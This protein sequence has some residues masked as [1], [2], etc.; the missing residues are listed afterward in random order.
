MREILLGLDGGGTHTRAV[1]VDR[2]GHVLASAEAGG[3]NPEHTPDAER[4]AHEAICRVVASAGRE[5]ADVTRIV[6]G[7]AGLNDPCDHVWAERQTDVPGLSCP[8]LQVNDAVIA[9]VGALR[10]QPGIIAISGTGS[11]VFGVTEAGRHVRNYDFGHYAPSSAGHLAR[12]A[13]YRLLIGDAKPADDGFAAQIFAHW[14]ADD[15][16]ALRQFAS[17]GFLVDDTA[18]NYRFG[19]MALLVTDAAQSGAPLAQSACNHAAAVLGVG[20]RL[21]GTCFAGEI[22]EIALIGGVV[23]SPYIQQAVTH[24]LAADSDGK[25]VPVEPAFPPEIGAAL[26]A[27]ERHGVVCDVNVLENLRSSAVCIRG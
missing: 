26:M 7:F 8:R 2:M 20:I 14:Q 6:A 4:N 16:S 25:F 3:S 21:V 5:L 13:M 17:E 18:R 15:L 22:V 27:L 9:H 12:D 24:A 10:S 1:A 11:I 19:E 23:R